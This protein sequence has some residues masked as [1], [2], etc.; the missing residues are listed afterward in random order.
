MSRQR[1]LT[2]IICQRAA[3][4]LFNNSS[5]TSRVVSYKPN[6]IAILRQFI[7]RC[8]QIS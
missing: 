4:L 1:K 8:Y 6:D 5:K 7:T 2:I 3:Y